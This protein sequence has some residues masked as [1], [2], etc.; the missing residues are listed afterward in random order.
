MQERSRPRP[1]AGPPTLAACLRWPT[2]PG[3][4]SGPSRPST[5]CGIALWEMRSARG[6]GKGVVYR[7]LTSAATGHRHPPPEAW[8]S[9]SD[10]VV[11]CG[12]D[13]LRPRRQ[14]GERGRDPRGCPRA[15]RRRGRRCKGSGLATEPSSGRSCGPRSTAPP[16][17]SSRSTTEPSRGRA[18]PRT[19]GIGR[20]DAPEDGCRPGASRSCRR[21]CHSF[22]PDHHPGVISFSAR[23][24]S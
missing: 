8:T 20:D 2:S 6:V 24:P 12:R 23:R 17:R 7:G 16:A 10:R 21:R 3:S 19:R 14:R 13:R 11:V 18:R 22:S 1:P 9:P 5:R 15:R 4:G